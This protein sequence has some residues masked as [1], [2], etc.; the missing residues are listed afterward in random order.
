MYGR[1]VIKRPAVLQKYIEILP[2]PFPNRAQVSRPH[3]LPQVGDAVFTHAPK[4]KAVSD[5]NILADTLISTP[6]TNHTTQEIDG[7]SKSS[8]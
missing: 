5:R 2:S 6:A 7:G 3:S 8:P 4:V 1:E